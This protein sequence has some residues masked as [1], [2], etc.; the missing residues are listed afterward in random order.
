M[1]MQRAIGDKD[2][3][4]KQLLDKI[5]ILGL[6]PLDEI[7]TATL[8][9][10]LN[11]MATL[12][13]AG[14]K[15]L[16][17]FKEIENLKKQNALTELKANSKKISEK[18]II[19][20]KP[21]EKLTRDQV[22]KNKA[23]QAMN[24]AMRLDLSITPMDVVFDSLD[25]VAGYQGS[26]FRIF[27][28][29]IDDAYSKYIQ[30]KQA[31]AEDIIS[32]SEELKLEDT[33][34]EKIGFYAAA[35]QEGGAEK[36]Q[37]LG[38]T[39]KE[40]E[41]IKLSENQ[42]KLYEAMRSKLD[43]LRPEI[44]EVMRVVYNEE[45]GEVKNYFPFMTDFEAMSD[46]E[47]RERFGNNVQQ[48][49]QA[50]KKNVEQGFTKKRV[51]G[52]Q[53]I[54]LNA[55]QIFL[56]HID[57]STYLITVG[58]ETKRL[59]EI[60][61][62]QEYAGSV[63]ELGQEIVRDWIDIVARKGK[64]NGQRD[65]VLDTMRR[66]TGVAVLGFKL[67][68]AIIQPTALLDG[69]SLIGG[70]AFEGASLITKKEWRQFIMNNMPEIKERI[71]DDVAFTEFGSKSIGDKVA[72][73]GFWALK[74]LDALTAS[75]VAAGAYTKYLEDNKIEL[76]LSNPNA[77]A[78]SYAQKIV[79]RT[80]ASS[81]FKDA[82]SALTRGT[83]TGSKSIDKLLLQFQTFMLNRWSLIKHDMYAAG[84]KGENK[85]QALNIAFWLTT[86]AFAETGLRRVSKE[87]INSITG[88]DDEE[89]DGFVEQV[90]RSLLS[91]I[92]FV[93]SVISFSQYG[94]MPIPAVAMMKKLGDIASALSK[95]KKENTIAKNRARFAISFIGWIFGIPGTVQ[96]DQIANKILQEKKKSL[97]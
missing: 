93:S 26:N 87:L 82:P 3:L 15:K 31:V 77:E 60:A 30:K 45:L 44:A 41:G 68:S 40:I 62:T 75:S 53:K 72:N 25:G 33:D 28:K 88:S 14:K 17:T 35:Q 65:N 19:L 84:I 39:K 36:L 11:D 91:N 73:A 55:M 48:F 83:I 4:S 54:K 38:F 92:P 59:G 52:K 13:D 22:M 67:S 23:A 89:E 85:A 56:G 96:A 97:I 58:K 16:E 79:R 9:N 27:K 34:F 12:V 61:A 24:W 43:G 81:F 10:V 64:A 71:G 29:T 50:P 47:I 80:Q 1:E 2:N 46:S 51:G 37:S 95:S 32:L 5:E 7:S 63:G 18:D 21:G 76:D 78:I 70:K 8:E 74:N 66:H 86:A 20:A 57:N 42:T 6:K 49:G 69:A 94:S 90:V